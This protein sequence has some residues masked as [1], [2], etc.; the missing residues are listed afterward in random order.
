MFTNVYPDWMKTQLEINDSTI[1][2]DDGQGGMA[3]VRINDDMPIP[4]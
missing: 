1:M 2:V 3:E 4:T